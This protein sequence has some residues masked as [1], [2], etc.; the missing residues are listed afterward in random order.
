MSAAGDLVADSL[1]RI[2][3][4]GHQAVE[5]LSTEQLA[6]RPAGLGNSIAWLIW[7]LARI[8]D[9]H[10][11]RLA[12]TTQIWMSAGWCDSFGLPFAPEDHGY[13][14]TS[15]Q[16]ASVVVDG[17]LLLGYLDD[18]TAASLAY[19]ATIEEWDEVVDTRW[20]P[21]V[22]RSVRVVSVLCDCLMHIGQAQYVRGLEPE[23]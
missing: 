3:D 20:D 1:S 17:S 8:Q 9:D 11:A 21:P 5:G 22:T 23:E 2:R 13:G 4:G 6:F 12:D 18:V 16:V 19:V 10:L 14:H 7:H 15:E